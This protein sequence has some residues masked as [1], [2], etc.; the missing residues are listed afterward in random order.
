MIAGIALLVLALIFL[1]Q[2]SGISPGQFV[3]M[4][5]QWPIEQ[6]LTV[7]VIGAVLLFLVV[8][9]I[10]QSDKLAQQA[11]AIDILQRRMN[12]L[13]DELAAVDQNQNGADAAMRYLVGSD[14]TVTIDDLQQRLAQAEAKASIQRG[15]NEAVDLPTRIDELR[16]RQQALRAQL[17]GISEKR[18]AI[19]PMLGELKERQ[20]LIE[21][22]LSDLEKD[23]SGNLLDVRIK[24]SESFL[25]RGQARLVALEGMVGTLTQIKERAERLQIEID[26]LKHGETG[27]KALFGEVTALRNKLDTALIA[28]EREENETI[29]DRVERLSKSKQEIDRR[30]AALNDCLGSLESLRGDISGHFEKL[31]TTLGEHLRRA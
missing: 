5:S 27:I 14:P 20:V 3:S 4:V 18:R 8:G 21:R 12:G 23:D 10:W 30:L 13:R 17:G 19:E 1:Q 16:Q 2:S 28:L 15:Q 29:S 25:H 26:P 31:N 9:G 11:K 24:D 6:K 7:A 22:S